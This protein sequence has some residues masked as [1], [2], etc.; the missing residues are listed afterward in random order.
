MY[1]ETVLIDPDIEEG[2]KTKNDKINGSKIGFINIFSNAGTRNKSDVFKHLTGFIA[3]NC[4][5]SKIIELKDS[6]KITYKE[7]NKF[8]VIQLFFEKSKILIRHN[9]KSY[10]HLIMPEPNM[11]FID[12][13]I[14]EIKNLGYHQFHKENDELQ[15]TCRIELI[16]GK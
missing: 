6:I 2:L 14:K 5:E 11:D 4:H 1:K 16:K 10:D 15:S 13:I 7:I 8:T 12:A 9:L 3:N